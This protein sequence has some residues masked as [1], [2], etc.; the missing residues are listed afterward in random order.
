M[1]IMQVADISFDELVKAFGKR[2]AVQLL[3]AGVVTIF[4][5]KLCSGDVDCARILFALTGVLLAA[6]VTDAL[7]TIYVP[8]LRVVALRGLFDG[9]LAGI[10]AGIVG[11]LL[12]F[13]RHPMTPTDYQDPQLYRVF[14]VLVYTVPTAAL[15]G[16][17]LGLLRPE[18]PVNWRRDLSPAISI[19]LATFLVIPWVLATQIAKRDAN[20][21]GIE[22]GD[23][24]IVFECFLVVYTALYAFAVKWTVRQIR[25]ATVIVAAAIAL[26]EAGTRLARWRGDE[27]SDGSVYHLEFINPIEPGGVANSPGVRY[28]S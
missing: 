23:I 6:G 1:E 13:G 11:G 9:L 5:D 10:I 17:C 22:V 16:L 18:T 19:L 15:L 4:R 25:R 12:G 27:S 21:Q 7:L 20:G 24:Q 2:A 3:L 14:R 28:L 26:A 8:H